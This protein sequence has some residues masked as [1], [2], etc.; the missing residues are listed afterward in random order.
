MLEAEPCKDIAI[1][2]LSLKRRPHSLTEEDTRG[3]QDLY[4]FCGA[5]GNRA[6]KHV[7][8]S[9]WHGFIRLQ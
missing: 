6:A 1:D 8:V 7:P 4:G 5:H 2:S 9:S 3:R